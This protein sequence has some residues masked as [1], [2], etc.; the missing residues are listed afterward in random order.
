M[1]LKEYL[2]AIVMEIDG[3]DIEVESVDASHSTGRKPVKTMNKTGKVA[4]FAQGIQEFSLRVT[5]PI[6][7]TGD[8]NWGAIKGSKITIYPTTAGGKRVSYVDCFTTSV[9]DKYQVDREAMRDL[10]MVALNRYEE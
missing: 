2:G 1:A 7:A 6:P 9:G 3:K 10:G 8:L 5:V 4:G